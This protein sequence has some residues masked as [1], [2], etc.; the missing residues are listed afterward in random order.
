MLKILL[1]VDIAKK[2][3]K[4]IVEIMYKN[5]VNLFNFLTL[6]FINGIFNMCPKNIR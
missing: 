3:K 4:N 5:C 1:L 2:K 6:I